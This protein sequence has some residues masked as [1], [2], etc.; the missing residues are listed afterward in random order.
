MFGAAFSY[1]AADLAAISPDGKHVAVVSKANVLGARL[2]VIDLSRAAVV[3][4]LGSNLKDLLLV[5]SP[6]ICWLNADR[7][8]VHFGHSDLAV[9]DTDGK[10]LRWLPVG[11][12]RFSLEPTGSHLL[13]VR[14]AAFSSEEPDFVHLMGYGSWGQVGEKRSAQIA[15]FHLKKSESQQVWGE[16]LAGRIITDQQGRA[17]VWHEI[18]KDTER[19]H[20][21]EP[22]GKA[23]MGRSLDE[24]AGPEA[25]ARFALSAEN[26]FERH[27]RPLGFDRDPNTLIV[28]SNVGRDT[29]GIYGLDLAKGQRTGIALELPD[30]DLAELHT[31]PLLDYSN[32]VFDPGSGRLAGVRYDGER[33]SALWIDEELRG[34]QARIEALM[35]AHGVQIENWDA[36]REKFIVLL[37]HRADAGTYAV[38]TRSTD[39]LRGFLP[40]RPPHP[41]APKVHVTPWKITA[42]DGTVLSGHL[43]LPLAP[44]RK[45]IPVVAFFQP[46][47]WQRVPT[48]FAPHVAALAMM[49]YA[50]I[51]VNHRGV[52][53]LGARHWLAGRGDADER[54][55]ADMFAAVDRVA[56]QAG[57]DA[58]RVAVCGARFGG[59]MALRAA[60]LLPQRVACAVAI[61]AETDLA[62]LERPIEL[63]SELSG[64]T[65]A[66]Q[67][68]FFGPTH[69]DLVRRSPVAQAVKFTQPVMFAMTFDSYGAPMKSLR[70]KLS[71][72]G[73]PVAWVDVAGGE[74]NSVRQ[75][76]MCVAV[77]KFL[78][79]HLGKTKP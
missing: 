8:L 66:A 77:E 52:L 21:R 50:V 74:E 45:P 68:A 79:E 17:R 2:R 41:A 60:Q 10:N 34:V 46:R 64:L 55:V 30:Y 6:R 57:L 26:Y 1:P 39:E 25:D 27:T 63:H 31:A 78:G 22:D 37:T 42:A 9:L 67:L 11:G 73:Q 20:V 40:V 62:V 4:D 14:I 51:E 29:V 44:A 47:L 49:G 53:G 19:F 70:R 76:R 23:G 58:Q 33:R 24:V 5:Y 7:M 71:A 32:L 75:G 3:A 48:G 38:Y 43:T 72:S 12:S 56:I 59:L 36:A 13:G 16:K 61:D 69:E 18:Q 65:S 35:P 15:K 28:A 54:A